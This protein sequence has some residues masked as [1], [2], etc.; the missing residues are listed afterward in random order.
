MGNAKFIEDVHNIAVLKEAQ[1]KSIWYGLT[2]HGYKPKEDAVIGSQIEESTYG[3][4]SIYEFNRDELGGARSK[5]GKITKGSIFLVIDR[6]LSAK[7]IFDK[8]D[9]LDNIDVQ[10]KAKEN[11]SIKLAYRID[12]YI[13]DIVLSKEAIKFYT[14]ASGDNPT[15]VL[16][17]ETAGGVVSILEALDAA[18]ERLHT[19]PENEEFTKELF[20]VCS[21]H[22]I[23]LLTQAK[24]L[25]DT[26]NSE[27]ISSG[28][29]G[30]YNGINIIETNNVFVDKTTDAAH[31]VEYSVLL[32]K[33]AVGYFDPR[34][35]VE[36]FEDHSTQITTKNLEDFVLCGKTLRLPKEL[37]VINY[38]VK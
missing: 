6:L 29:R 13:R 34:S 25:V 17:K 3:G 4:S 2:Y 21:P 9:D 1:R 8:L 30:K 10:A 16:G 22:A 5:G 36:F 28:Y 38:K 19:L 14:G 31:P 20:Y 11:H 35:W 26:D 7:T 24:V 37:L 15:P 23:T 32:T 33:D 12:K 27:F 18:K